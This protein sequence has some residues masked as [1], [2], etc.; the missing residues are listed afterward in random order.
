MATQSR[1][2]GDRSAPAAQYRLLYADAVPGK[3]ILQHRFRFRFDSLTFTEFSA[4]VTRPTSSPGMFVVEHLAGLLSVEVE[5][6]YIES[7]ASLTA[8]RT[9]FDVVMAIGSLRNAPAAVIRPVSRA[10]R[11]VYGSTAAGRSSPTPYRRWVREGSL[12]FDEWRR[13][14]TDRGRRGRNGSTSTVCS[15]CSDR[16]GSSFVFFSSGVTSDFDFVQTCVCRVG[17]RRRRLSFRRGVNPRVLRDWPVFD[18]WRHPPCPTSSVRPELDLHATGR[19]H[20]KAAPTDTATFQRRA[21]GHGQRQRL[22]SAKQTP[23]SSA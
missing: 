7:V 10:R 5:T 6:P 22:A 1:H 23:R 21:L 14:S 2:E 11:A 15:T 4:C 9:D 8:L 17:S 20:R 18:R 19:R 3:R 16:T 12:P 13:R